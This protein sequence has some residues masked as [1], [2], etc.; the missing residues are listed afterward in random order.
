[1]QKTEAKFTYRNNENG[2]FC[3]H[4]YVVYTILTITYLYMFSFLDITSKYVY[5][6]VSVCVYFFFEGEKLSESLI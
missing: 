4:D 6:C 3:I 2:I 1:M 5:L